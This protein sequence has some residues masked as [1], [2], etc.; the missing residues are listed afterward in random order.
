[1]VIV[2]VVAVFDS[3]K[4]FEYCYY[5]LKLCKNTIIYQTLLV[6]FILSAVIIILLKTY[7]IGIQYNCELPQKI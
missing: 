4:T 7:S 3:G 5:L 1:M 6:T 2:Y